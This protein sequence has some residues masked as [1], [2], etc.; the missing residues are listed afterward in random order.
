MT[1]IG[2]GRHMTPFV[3]PPGLPEAVFQGGEADRQQQG[4]LQTLQSPPR[5][6]QEAGDLEGSSHSAGALKTV[7]KRTRHEALTV[8]R[9]LG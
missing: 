7:C 9:H 6:D 8:R 1:V 5:L 2:G 4:V 3:A